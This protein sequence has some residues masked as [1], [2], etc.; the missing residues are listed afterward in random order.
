MDTYFAGRVNGSE[1]GGMGFHMLHQRYGQG[2]YNQK[3][4]ES[5]L[6]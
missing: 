5:L 6:T 4:K 3:A 2:F 1:S